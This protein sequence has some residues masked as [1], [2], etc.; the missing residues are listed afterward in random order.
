M[1]LGFNVEYSKN[2]RRSS[3]CLVKRFR[4]QNEVNFFAYRALNTTN[5]IGWL[6]C[7]REHTSWQRPSFSSARTFERILTLTETILYFDSLRT[8]DAPSPF[9][10]WLCRWYL[11]RQSSFIYHTREI[12][13]TIFDCN[14][15][16]LERSCQW[17][18]PIHGGVTYDCNHLPWKS[19]V[20]LFSSFAEI[21]PRNF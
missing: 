4:L 18:S 12:N 19:L 13:F 10:S 5:T 16:R 8:R 1:K 15:I 2:P 20:S 9:S 7:D 14:L 11:L 17:I 6:L 21:W 3:R